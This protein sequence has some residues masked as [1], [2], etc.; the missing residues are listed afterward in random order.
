MY[1]IFLVKCIF[2]D[3]CCNVLLSIND[4][5]P[6]Y[7]N[8]VVN[9]NIYVVVPI[10]SIIVS[11]PEDQ[12]VGQ[13][14]TLKCDITTVRGVT[15]RV[16]IVWSSNG[17]QLRKA[18]GISANSMTHNSVLYTASYV[19]GQLS[20]ADEDRTYECMAMI[21]AQSPVTASDSVILNATSKYHCR[22]L[23]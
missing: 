14:L 8:Y 2:V 5:P 23:C 20:T 1:S 9:M 12:I 17:S 15:S 18:T 7:I 3:A 19:I 16:D 10:P 22:L 6:T 4:K 21:N 13:S 11:A